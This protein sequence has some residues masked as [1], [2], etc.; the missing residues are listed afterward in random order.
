MLGDYTNARAD[1]RNAMN[2]TPNFENAVIGLNRL[3][4]YK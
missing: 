1:Y 4:K 2:I 3:D